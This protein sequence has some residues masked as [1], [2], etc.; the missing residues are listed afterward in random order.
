M[1]KLPNAEHAHVPLEKLRDYA[2]NPL[3][4]EGKHKAR[5]FRAALGF[6][7]ADAEKLS[8]L[9]LEAAQTGE[10]TKSRL[11]PEGQ[12]YV[13]D[14]SIE[15]EHGAVAIRTAWI[16]ETNK[17]FPRLGTCYARKIA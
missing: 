17:D 2:L 4:D 3:H 6:T 14:F 7:Q 16:I 1:A 15:G 12:M 13:L 8:H 10:A 9:I 5:V 11:L